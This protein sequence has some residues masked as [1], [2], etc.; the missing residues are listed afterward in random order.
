MVSVNQDF[1]KTLKTLV[2]DTKS[3]FSYIYG[4]FYMLSRPLL[5]TCD[6][7]NQVYSR[8]STQTEHMA[9][10]AKNSYRYIYMKR[11]ESINRVLYRG[12]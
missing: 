11:N 3:G 2:A 8:D 12:C 1:L 9:R 10:S 6:M 4:L 7:D 5:A